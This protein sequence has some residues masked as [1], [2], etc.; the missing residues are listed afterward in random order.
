M[1]FHCNHQ[2]WN[3]FAYTK[4]FSSIID[5]RKWQC[6]YKINVNMYSHSFIILT[7]ISVPLYYK[8]ITKNQRIKRVSQLRRGR[9]K[10][11]GNKYNGY[12]ANVN[13]EITHVVIYNY[14]IKYHLSICRNHLNRGIFTLL[15]YYDCSCI[16]NSL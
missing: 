10:K 6:H 4:H 13:M 14:K 9:K 16:S 8:V 2:I 15:Y 3:T 11:K 12:E 1:N 7:A 5:T